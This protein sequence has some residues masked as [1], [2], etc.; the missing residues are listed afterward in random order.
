MNRVIYNLQSFS[1]VHIQHTDAQ[2]CYECAVS[3]HTRQCNFQVQVDPAVYH[4]QC[5]ETYII[6]RTDSHS[7]HTRF[8]PSTATTVL[9]VHRRYTK[10]RFSLCSFAFFVAMGDTA[11]ANHFLIEPHNALAFG[12]QTVCPSI[13]WPHWPH[14]YAYNCTIAPPVNTRACHPAPFHSGRKKLGH[15]GVRSGLPQT[16]GVIVS[17][18]GGQS[19]LGTFGSKACRTTGAA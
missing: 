6:D 9:A 1:V 15:G 10:G 16:P 13:D 17:V 4:S 8:T 7:H 11:T 5:F 2:C 3:N 19:G 14:L 18:K 12:I